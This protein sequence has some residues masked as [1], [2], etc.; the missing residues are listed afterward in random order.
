MRTASETLVFLEIGNGAAFAGGKAEAGGI[1]AGYLLLAPA[2]GLA[3]AREKAP[4]GALSSLNARSSDFLENSAPYLV[5]GT[6]PVICSGLVTK[7]LPQ[8]YGALGVLKFGYCEKKKGAEQQESE[9]GEGDD[10]LSVL[11][12]KAGLGG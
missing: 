5:I 3:E 8:S 7:T 9:A 11:H 2:I 6:V 1:A 4:A 12:E 10:F